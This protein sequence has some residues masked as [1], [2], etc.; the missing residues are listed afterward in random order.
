MTEY[1][2]VWPLFLHFRKITVKF[3]GVRKFR[4]FTVSC[5]FA[6]VFRTQYRQE[7]EGSDSDDA[8]FMNPNRTPRQ[9]NREYTESTNSIESQQGRAAVAALGA[10]RSTEE[11][12]RSRNE[13]EEDT[14][15]EEPEES[16]YYDNTSMSYHFRWKIVISFFCTKH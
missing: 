11:Q 2:K 10:E 16:M 13:R 4:N 8:G 7:P 15:E 1:P 3:F 6:D 14:T 5:L 9:R 12:R